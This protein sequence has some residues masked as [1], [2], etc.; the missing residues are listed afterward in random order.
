MFKR[1][2]DSQKIFSDKELKEFSSN[3]YNSDILGNRIDVENYLIN[4]KASSKGAILEL[5]LSTNY[6][7]K[8]N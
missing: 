6:F 8:K 5:A 7:L 1:F 4:D 2:F 3:N